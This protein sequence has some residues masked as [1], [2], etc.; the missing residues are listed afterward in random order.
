MVAG[1][2]GRGQFTMRLRQGLADI[3]RGAAPDLH[4]WMRPP[5]SQ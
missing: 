3:Q 1:G 4:G 5:V 2:G